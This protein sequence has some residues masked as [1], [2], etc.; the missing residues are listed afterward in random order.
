[1]ANI[2]SFRARTEKGIFV[3]EKA[4]A[5]FWRAVNIKTPAECWEWQGGRHYKG[6]GEFM[7]STKVK[8][9]SHRFAWSDTN[10]EIPLGAYVC[11]SCDNP[12]CCN[13]N[14]LF[15][16]TSKAN[17]EDAMRK[18]RHAFGERA[19]RAKLKEAEVLEIRRLD[20]VG[21]RTRLSLAAQFG[22]SGRQITG[23]CR[24]DSWS[25]I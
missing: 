14:H 1:M 6:Y 25:H 9:K 16:G 19:G 24:K 20:S 4:S 7:V 11:H 18:R 17:K 21:G 13:P 3:R 12:P 23:I 22:I 2:L 15:I 5:R 8:T 10:G